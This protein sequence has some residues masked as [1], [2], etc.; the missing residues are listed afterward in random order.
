VT[1]IPEESGPR[2]RLAEK[3]SEILVAGSKLKF[4]LNE[5]GE[6][7]ILGNR[8][9]LKALAAICSGL[10]DSAEGDHYHLNEN[11]WGTESGSIPVV[12]YRHENLWANGDPIACAI[13]IL[14]QLMII[15][16]KALLTPQYWEDFLL[17][18]ARKGCSNGGGFHVRPF[19]AGK[20]QTEN[21]NFT[22]EFAKNHGRGSHHS[23][24][25]FSCI[26]YAPRTAKGRMLTNQ[27][28]SRKYLA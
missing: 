7:E 17:G 20:K 2:R 12:V 16:A 10:A 13:E 1:N 27:F 8:L 15:R 28:N 23:R 4:A 14:R 22:A 25:P 3:D 24:V 9:G 5:Q 18:A 11:F 6:L 26:R 19:A 21:L